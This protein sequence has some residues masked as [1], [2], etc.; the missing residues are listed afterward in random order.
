MQR[1]ERP[2]WRVTVATDDGKILELSA[3]AELGQL[4]I[5]AGDTSR[6]PDHVCTLNRKS[7]ALDNL[8][9]ALIEAKDHLELVAPIAARGPGADPL[10]TADGAAAPSDPTLGPSP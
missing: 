9:D 3:S 10:A 4:Y 7:K 5:A 2:S 1:I 6:A 8:I